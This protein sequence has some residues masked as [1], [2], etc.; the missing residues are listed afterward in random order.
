MSEVDKIRRKRIKLILYLVLFYFNVTLIF[1][2][3]YLFVGWTGLGHLKDHYQQ[4]TLVHPAYEEVT[5]A[6]YF[7]IVT[8][9]AV[10]YGDVTPFGVA[11]AIAIM[12]SMI[13]Y[14]LPAVV[15]IQ[16]LQERDKRKAK[17][18]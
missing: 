12:Q 4:Y 11:K 7:S 9:F 5:T 18:E 1:T 17:I 10:G 3:I 2:F 8:L 6:F 15:I 14:M 16:Y 13:G